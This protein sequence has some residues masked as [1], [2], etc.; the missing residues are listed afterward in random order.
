MSMHPLTRTLLARILRIESL[1]T[2]D[3]A[4]TPQEACLIGRLVQHV[5]HDFVTILSKPQDAH[6][7]F[8]SHAIQHG[9]FL[10][11]TLMVWLQ[12]CAFG[13]NSNHL[14]YSLPCFCYFESECSNVMT[15][16][17]S[18]VQQHRGMFPEPFSAEEE[19]SHRWLSLMLVYVANEVVNRWPSS[20]TLRCWHVPLVCRRKATCSLCQGYP[21]EP[22]HPFA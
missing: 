17:Q 12:S 10:K 14:A 16:E 11:K 13:E 4:C 18:L 5:A 1:C 21:E 22:T 20:A 7:L 2:P 19:A 3:N 9:L 8:V 15:T 6:A